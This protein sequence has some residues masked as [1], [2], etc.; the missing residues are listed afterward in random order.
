MKNLR[1]GKDISENIKILEETLESFGIKARV[2]QVSRGPAITRYEIQPPQG[3]KVSRIVSLA[4]DIALSMAAPD[5][6]IEAPIPG[7]AAVGIEV[8]NRE[9]SMVHLRELIEAQEF[10]QSPSRLTVALGKDIAGNRSYRIWPKCPTCSLQGQRGQ[11]RA[12]ASTH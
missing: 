12:F 1:V 7:K 6:R 4:D 11:A 5:V 2:T 3:I 8:P 9:V 10:T